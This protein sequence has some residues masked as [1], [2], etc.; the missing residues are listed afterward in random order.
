MFKMEFTTSNAA[1]R[2]PFTGEENETYKLAESAKILGNISREM[3]V[4]GQT[5]GTIKDV[6]GH[7]IGKWKL[8]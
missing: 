5:S 4:Y 3:A 6:N 2:D 8:E 1:F 7:T